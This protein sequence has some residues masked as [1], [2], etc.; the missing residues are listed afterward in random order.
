M[1]G[2]SISPEIKGHKLPKI[3]NKEDLPQP[4]GPEIIKFSLFFKT[5]FNFSINILPLGVTTIT[6]SIR[7]Y[8]LSVTSNLPL[9]YISCLV[10]PA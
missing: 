10:N 1:G 4:F 5:K 3:L 7:I 8:L 9:F 2:R 6:F